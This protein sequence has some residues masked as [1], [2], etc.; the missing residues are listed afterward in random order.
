[1]PELPEVET[2]RRTLEPHLLGRRVTRVLV[3][4]ADV[5]R[6]TTARGARAAL[7]EGAVVRGLVRHG[8]QL[9]VI[10]D[11]GAVV[12]AHMGMSGQL[13]VA[14]PR[15]TPRNHVHVRWTFENGT[16][17]HFRDPRRFGGVWAYESL[18]ALR[19]DR[20]QAL[21]PDALHIR[22]GAL[23]AAAGGSRRPI[24]A[25]LLDQ[26][27][28]AGVGNIYADESLFLCG[29]HPLRPASS[30]DRRDLVALAGSIRLV[31]REAIR[32]RGSSL[33][34]FL[35]A[36]LRP[37]TQQDRF[38]AYGRGGRPCPRCGITLE[39]ILVGGRTTTF[40]PRCQ[41]ASPHPGR[42]AFSTS[43]SRR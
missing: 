2:I 41:P 6:N 14:A 43:D 19:A 28:L 34:D 31:L 30:L 20:W 10:F 36:E 13:F 35:D 9:A 32:A 25:C 40:C 16:V 17:L 12:H 8:K 4:R 29:L 15:G 5:V 26:R 38:R 27:V 1:M 3:R 23:H 24:K 7:G 22:A 18:D 42:A 21:G 37:G 39:T 33:R 11:S